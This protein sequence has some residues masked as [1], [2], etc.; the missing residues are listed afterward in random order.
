MKYLEVLGKDEE[1]NS[2]EFKANFKWREAY[3]KL[4]NI[5]HDVANQRNIK[6]LIDAAANNAILFVSSGHGT[7]DVI[8]RI[9]NVLCSNVKVTAFEIVQHLMEDFIRDT[10]SFHLMCPALGVKYLILNSGKTV[11]SDQ[12]FKI[13]NEPVIRCF[14]NAK[15]VEIKKNFAIRPEVLS[16]VMGN[17]ESL[18]IGN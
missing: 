18:T 6:L 14:P 13:Y 2:W 10:I 5:N 12:N 15:Y 4:H 7:S 17:V 8:N 3:I 1:S 9:M 11:L 16:V